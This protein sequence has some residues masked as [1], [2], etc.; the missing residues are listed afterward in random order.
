MRRELGTDKVI[1]EGES[2]MIETY[3]RERFKCL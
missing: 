2:V 1:S 3:L